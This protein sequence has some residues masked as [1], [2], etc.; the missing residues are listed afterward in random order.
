MPVLRVLVSDV[1]E[2]IAPLLTAGFTLTDRWG[3][4]FAILSAG[5]AHLWVSGPPTSAAK[6]TEQLPGDQARLAQ[7]RPVQQVDDVDAAIPE[8]L[9][10]GWS[11]A[12][13]PVSGP[14]G[15]QELLQRGSAF[16]EVF[17]GR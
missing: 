11:V 4:P 9:A 1:D 7:V 16:L 3:P 10:D 14:G 15:T 8:H 17:A 13:G 6:L 5:D 2:A 12:A